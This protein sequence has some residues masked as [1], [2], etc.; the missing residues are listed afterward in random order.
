VLSRFHLVPERNGRTDLL[1]QYRGSVCWRAIKTHY[2]ATNWPPGESTASSASDSTIVDLACCNNCYEWMT[3]WKPPLVEAKLHYENKLD[4]G[5]WRY[6]ANRM[7]ARRRALCIQ[8]TLTR[9][10]TIGT[11]TVIFAVLLSF[12]CFWLFLTIGTLLVH[13]WYSF[14]KP[15]TIG[16]VMVKNSQETVKTAKMTIG[17]PIVTCLLTVRRIQ[18]VRVRVRWQSPT[19]ASSP[20]EEW[21][22][23]FSR[24]QQCTVVLELPYSTEFG[25]GRAAI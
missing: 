14:G 4:A 24:G 18:K 13:Y 6:H 1:Y 19:A 16:T 7:D 20:L 23:T 22:R 15:V 12:D 2:F 9:H 8:R 10:V 11:P 21:T 3:I 25:R 17:V 5:I